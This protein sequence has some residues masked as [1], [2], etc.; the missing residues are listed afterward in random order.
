[1]IEQSTLDRN[2]A[3]RFRYS[4][5]AGSGEGPSP[6]RSCSAPFMP[7]KSRT[8]EYLRFPNPITFT[9][10]VEDHR[11]SRAGAPRYPAMTR[12]LLDLLD[13]HGATG[14]FFLVGDVARE[15]P[16]L[17]REIGARGHEI[18]SHSYRHVPLGE[19]VP[20]QFLAAIRQSKAYLEDLTGRQV[21]GF[22]APVFSLTRETIWATEALR[23]AGFRYSS[24]VLPAGSFAYGLP[25]APQVPFLWASGLLEIPCPVGRIGPLTLPFLG[26]MY[27]RYL[28]PWRL[29]QL[30]AQVVE[31]VLWSY[32]HPYD[33]DT[34]EPFAPARG[35]TLVGSLFLW[36]N[37]SVALR[38][39]SALLTLN[40]SQTFEARFDQLHEA[41]SS[42]CLDGAFDSG[43]MP[44]PLM[45][46]IQS[47]RA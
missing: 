38:R 11:A 47:S 7:G 19:E 35:S 36:C 3:P 29:R 33:I 9:V 31:S 15:A 43:R 37:R 16:D 26:G 27:L 4:S 24:S 10:D 13:E 46:R 45:A 21:A 20:R 14:T 12:R 34:E 1:V 8:L 32:C 42:R 39:L 17:V 30:S 25:A 5:L 6:R 40:R 2:E 23:E 44:I 41:A 28:P 22:R 18:A